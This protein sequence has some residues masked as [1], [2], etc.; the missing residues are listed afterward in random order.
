[1][2]RPWAVLRILSLS[3]VRMNI[4]NA[5]HMFLFFGMTSSEGG[6]GF[7]FHRHASSMRRVPCSVK[8]MQ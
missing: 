3:D 4:L 1:V 2:H 7:L 6:K 8:R 5:F